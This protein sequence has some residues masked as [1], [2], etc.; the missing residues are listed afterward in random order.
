MT[1]LAVA[2]KAHSDV[3]VMQVAGGCTSM[4]TDSI[5][6]SAGTAQYERNSMLWRNRSL[7]DL[8]WCSSAP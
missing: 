3:T 2:G 8:W 4:V 5:Q 1:N 7:T 6:V